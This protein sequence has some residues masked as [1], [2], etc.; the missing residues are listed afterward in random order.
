MKTTLTG[1][2]L[3]LLVSA[4]ALA[5]SQTTPDEQA[6]LESAYLGRIDEVQRLVPDLLPPDTADADQ[7]T[8]LMFASFNGHTSVM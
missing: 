5:Q 8:P 7:R 3:L 4:T 1:L 2:I 6:L